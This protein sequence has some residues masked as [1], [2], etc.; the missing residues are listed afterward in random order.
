MF[1]TPA[2]I[3]TLT[4]RAHKARQIEALRTMGIPHWINAAGA[5]IVPLAALEGRS[6]AAH[7]GQPE[8]WTPK[9]LRNAA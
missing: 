6:A 9:P 1:L 8:T 3:H 5:P 7:D 2:E 4:G